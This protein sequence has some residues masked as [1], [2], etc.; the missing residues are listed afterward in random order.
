MLLKIQF[1]LTWTA[2]NQTHG[3]H[4]GRW[5]QPAGKHS[6][7]P[8][9]ERHIRDIST[10][11]SWALSIIL[12]V[13]WEC[14]M[15]M[16]NHSD[17]LNSLTCLIYW[18]AWINGFNSFN[19][20]IHFLHRSPTISSAVPTA[21]SVRCLIFFS[22]FEEV[23]SIRGD[24]PLTPSFFFFS[25][26]MVVTWADT[27]WSLLKPGVAQEFQEPCWNRRTG[28]TL[29]F[30][31]RVNGLFHAINTET[32][33]GSVTFSDLR[34]GVNKNCFIPCLFL[35]SRWIYNKTWIFVRQV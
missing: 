27:V 14:Q 25:Y 11:T 7:A 24:E 20:G 35:F 30:L 17:G 6:A 28:W 16:Y 21:P 22:T 4:K 29:F 3:W 19:I 23:S 31:R 15:M 10:L 12:T 1:N 13:H 32:S 33:V 18:G 2:E 26:A 8:G 9:R 5:V 34:T